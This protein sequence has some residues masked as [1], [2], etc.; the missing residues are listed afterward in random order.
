MV[1]DQIC[2]LAHLNARDTTLAFVSR[3]PIAEIEALKARMGWTMPW[4]ETRD[5]FNDDFGVTDGGFGLNVFLRT[6]DGLF[7]TYFTKGRGVESLG[8]VW[9]LLDITP[10]GRQEAWQDAPPGTPQTEPYRWWRRHDE[11]EDV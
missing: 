1:A 11:Y 2:H 10:Y 6:A 4:Y 5:G 8:P 3:A 9:S 7:R